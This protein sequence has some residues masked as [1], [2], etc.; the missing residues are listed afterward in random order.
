MLRRCG[1][2]DGKKERFLKLFTSQPCSLSS[3]ASQIPSATLAGL[4]NIGE[5]DALNLEGIVPSEVVANDD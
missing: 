5:I 2:L 1:L 4:P 3:I